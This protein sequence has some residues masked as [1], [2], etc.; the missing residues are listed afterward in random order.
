[1]SGSNNDEQNYTLPTE[2]F[3]V[4]TL[5]H[6]GLPITIAAIIVVVILV[7]L[8]PVL[9]PLVGYEDANYGSMYYYPYQQ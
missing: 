1:M 3:S 9:L 5:G 2:H 7:V 8:T 4:P 6:A